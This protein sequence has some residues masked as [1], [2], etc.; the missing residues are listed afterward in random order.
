MDDSSNRFSSLFLEDSGTITKRQKQVIKGDFDTSKP[1]KLSPKVERFIE[2]IPPPVHQKVIHLLALQNEQCRIKEDYQTELQALERKYASKSKPLYAA[3]AE[4][5]SRATS[6]GGLSHMEGFRGP[7]VGIPEFWLTVLQH[8]AVIADLIQTWDDEP[9]TFL[10]DIRVEY[11]KSPAL[12]YR[13]LFEFAENEFFTNKTLSKTYT[14]ETGEENLGLFYGEVLGDTIYWKP[15]KE[16]P[17]PLGHQT[18][19]GFETQT[20]PESFFEFFSPL[21]LPPIGSPDADIAEMKLELDYG[22]GE[23]FKEKIVP[24]AVDWF[25]GG[26]ADDN[27]LGGGKGT[28]ESEGEWIWSQEYSRYYRQIAVDEHGKPVCVW[29]ETETN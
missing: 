6:D 19:N 14:Y 16:L 3:R 7:A 27:K 1:R 24:N 26:A 18:L 11:L 4:V 20:P 13:L 17:P 29:A 22:Y 8:H 5:V 9:L 15:G 28:G 2:T 25:T 23:I 21:Q 12:G 10:T